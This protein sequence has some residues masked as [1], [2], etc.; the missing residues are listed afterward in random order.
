MTKEL[1]DM[2]GE[3]LDLISEAQK[4]IK[5]RRVDRIC[6][7]AAEEKLKAAKVI[8]GMIFYEQ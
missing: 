8:L 5:D 4:I 6:L 1:F 3:A 7:A 2:M